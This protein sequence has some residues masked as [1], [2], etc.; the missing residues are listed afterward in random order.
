MMSLRDASYSSMFQMLSSTSDASG[1]RFLATYVYVYDMM[2]RALILGF[3]GVCLYP[4][5]E[6]TI[7]YNR[8]NNYIT[9]V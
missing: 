9:K 1:I 2:A 7:Q 8:G 3:R 4:N 5:H 6:M